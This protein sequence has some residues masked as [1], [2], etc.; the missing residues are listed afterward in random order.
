MQ[1]VVLEV[2]R[3]GEAFWTLLETYCHE[4]I[5][6]CVLTQRVNLWMPGNN[7]TALEV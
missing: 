3:V 1:F 2:R 4:L 7:S 5:F 6:P